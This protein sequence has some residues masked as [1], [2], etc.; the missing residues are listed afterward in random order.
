MRTAKD[1]PTA[2]ISAC[3]KYRYR[4]GRSWGG[5]GYVNFVMLN[6]STADAVEDD[7]T[8]VRC[9][10]Y[11][12]LWG[13]DG[14]VVTNL[15][16]FRATDPKD[17]KRA[18]DPVGPDNNG[19]ILA[20]AFGANLVVAAWGAHGT[21]MDRA[22]AV[23]SLFRAERVKPVALRMTKGGEPCHPLRLPCDLQPILPVAY[24]PEGV[25]AE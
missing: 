16:A 3:G 14:I 11:A 10:N 22:A 17:M 8:I 1:N 9:I 19:H 25:K 13:H 24:G 2:V 5:R 21:H 4:L 20:V 7:N 18:A 6:P 12:K 15:F 23:R